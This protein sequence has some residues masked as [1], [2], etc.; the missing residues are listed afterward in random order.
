MRALVV[1]GS[2]HGGTME[3]GEWVAEGLRAIPVTVHIALKD[4]PAQLTGA[5]IIAESARVIDVLLHGEDNFRRARRQRPARFR[6]P[7]LHDNRMALR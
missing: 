6:L 4:V 3:M 2:R 7:G 1:V 5:Q